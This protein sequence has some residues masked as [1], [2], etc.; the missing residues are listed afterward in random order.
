M[1][2]H[3]G[4]AIKCCVD[5]T[6]RE[7]GCHSTCEEYLKQKAKRDEMNEKRRA[8]NDVQTDFLRVRNN[9]LSRRK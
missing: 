1:E 9:R 2:L 7:L 6:K 5:C 8:F 3:T 4:R